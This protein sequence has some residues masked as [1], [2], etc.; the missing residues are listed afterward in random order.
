MA[1]REYISSKWNMEEVYLPYNRF[2]SLHSNRVESSGHTQEDNK[3]LKRV[4]FQF[5]EASTIH[6]DDIRTANSPEDVFIGNNAKDPG[7]GTYLD[8]LIEHYLYQTRPTVSGNNFGIRSCQCCLERNRDMNCNLEHN[9]HNEFN[10]ND[11]VGKHRAIGL[12]SSPKGHTHIDDNE[13]SHDSQWSTI[14][15]PVESPTSTVH[16]AEDQTKNS[17]F[18]ERLS[19]TSHYPDLGYRSVQYLTHPEFAINTDNTYY[20]QKS[21]DPDILAADTNYNNNMEKL[22]YTIK[23]LELS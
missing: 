14:P 20:F 3:I 16:P 17:Y 13:R 23:H 7:S 9:L 2:S 12:R 10:T 15:G 21:L 18:T 8:R 1:T 4:R 11:P 19:T 22:A 6:H 5:D